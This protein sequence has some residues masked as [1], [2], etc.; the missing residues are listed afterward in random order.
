VPHAIIAGVIA[1]YIAVCNL[2]KN[3]VSQ[4]RLAEV[5]AEL[6]AEPIAAMQV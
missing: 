6:T 5:A 3:E 1:V 4:T 2:F